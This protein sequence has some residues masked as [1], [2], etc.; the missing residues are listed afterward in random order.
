MPD[1]T[2]SGGIVHITADEIVAGY[3][4]HIK[5]Y[6]RNLW[7][8]VWST[9]SA[10]SGSWSAGG[11]F[12]DLTTDQ[13]ISGDKT[14]AQ[15]LTALS[16]FQHDTSYVETGNEP[17]GFTYWDSERH[18]LTTIY[19]W[20][21]KLQHGFELYTWGTD[22]GNNYPEG[23]PVSVS[24]VPGGRVALLQTDATDDTSVD[25]YIGLLTTPV[26]GGNRLATREGRV[27][28][29]DCTGNGDLTV[30][31]E[32]WVE[33]DWIY[34]HPTAAG[35]LTNIAPSGMQNTI[36][37]GTVTVDR[38]NGTIELDRDVPHKIC[39]LRRVS[40]DMD[41]RVDKDILQYNAA[42]SGWVNVQQVL[43]DIS[44]VNTDPGNND[45]L[46]Y[47]SENSRWIAAA[48]AGGS[49]VRFAEI[50]PGGGPNYYTADIWEFSDKSG[51][52]FASGASV[53]VMSITTNLNAGDMIP[54]QECVA[55]SFGPP[56]HL[57]DWECVQQLGAIGV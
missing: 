19:E 1:I 11:D 54:V 46:T 43:N 17:M 5:E 8:S 4:K 30:G 36:R 39:D 53:Y 45:V 55:G 38:D 9:V 52:Q 23:T 29:I 3:I 40:I 28:G 10:N 41:N 25:N 48:P 56:N 7:T 16:G 22:L 35:K 47:D 51:E 15:V 2:V 42:L 57:C 32:N 27:N 21:A 20:G 34:V 12:V 26:D 31:S 18:C 49:A 14:F 50:Y 6:E 44:N 13:S 33:G 37:V 24:G